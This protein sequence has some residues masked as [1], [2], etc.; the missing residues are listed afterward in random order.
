[1]LKK[2]N[3]IVYSYYFRPSLDLL[4]PLHLR[5]WFCHCIQVNV[6]HGLRVPLLRGPAEYVS[7]HILFN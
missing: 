3:V 5:N 4:K 7:F 2:N 6:A 1:M